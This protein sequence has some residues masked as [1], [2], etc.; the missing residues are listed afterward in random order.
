M[1]RF[2]GVILAL[3]WCG[4]TVPAG[5]ADQRPNIIAIL[6]DDIGYGDLLVM[7]AGGGGLAIGKGPWKLIPAAANK[8]AAQLY[9]LG[10]DLAETKNLA[11][12][13]PDKVK[14][15]ADFLKTTRQTGRSREAGR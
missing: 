15:L 13:N 11:V 4:L 6:A 10:D 12:Q 9:N 7:H 14:E 2:R 5:A 3:A 8:G 1:F